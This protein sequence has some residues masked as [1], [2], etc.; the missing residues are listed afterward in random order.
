MPSLAPLF[1]LSDNW[2]GYGSEAP[3]ALSLHNAAL[4]LDLLRFIGAWP[5]SISASAEG[6]V[7]LLFVRGNRSLLVEVYNDGGLCHIEYAADG[8]GGVG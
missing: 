2:N 5:E 3:N 1:N 8:A 7:A 6:G 4:F